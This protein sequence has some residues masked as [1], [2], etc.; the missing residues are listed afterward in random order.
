VLSYTCV[1]RW[2]RPT[3]DTVR[4]S[5]I[6]VKHNKSR[7][8]ASW[9]DPQVCVCVCFLGRPVDVYVCVCVRERE[10]ERQRECV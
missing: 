9:K 6:L 7:R 3:A 8:P 1:C 5:H 2:D 4:A 10:R